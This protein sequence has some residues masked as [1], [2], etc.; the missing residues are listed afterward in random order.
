M[1]KEVK[2]SELPKHPYRQ[3]YQL[4][5]MN[6][7]LPREDQ[8]KIIFRQPNCMELGIPDMEMITPRIYISTT[9]NIICIPD[10]EPIL[11]PMEFILALMNFIPLTPTATPEDNTFIQLLTIMTVM[12]FLATNK[13]PPC[14]PMVITTYNTLDEVDRVLRPLL[15]QYNMNTVEDLK[16]LRLGEIDSFIIMTNMITPLPMITEKGRTMMFLS[17]IIATAYMDIILNKISSRTSIAN[18]I[19]DFLIEKACERI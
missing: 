7:F 8:I 16:K 9:Q 11:I 13:K 1:G 3:I 5:A 17:D 6:N 2:I 15:K 18:R 14:N 10:P 12:Y 4:M 19:I